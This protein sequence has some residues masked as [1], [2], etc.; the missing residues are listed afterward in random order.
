MAE[1]YTVDHFVADMM[2]AIT[3]AQK[4]G[5]AASKVAEVTMGIAHAA[6]D[7][8]YGEEGNPDALAEVQAQHPTWQ[9]MGQALKEAGFLTAEEFNFFGDSTKVN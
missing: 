1:A 6:W 2:K 7:E 4:S 5:V 3:K 8:C 9:S